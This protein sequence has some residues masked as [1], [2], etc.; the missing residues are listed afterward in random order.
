MLMWN[1]S[2]TNICNP[3]LV[4]HQRSSMV[5]VKL[6]PPL[7]VLVW[8]CNFAAN[9]FTCC[10]GAVLV[11][12]IFLSQVVFIQ[13]FALRGCLKVTSIKCRKKTTLHKVFVEHAVSLINAEGTAVTD[14]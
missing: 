9:L 6:A 2:G 11:F 13:Y 4:Q 3:R 7:T 5:C 12:L 8:K 10:L 1:L 14:L